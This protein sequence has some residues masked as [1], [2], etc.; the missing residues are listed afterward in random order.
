M[1]TTTTLD[2]APQRRGRTRAPAISLAVLAA[3]LT[4][5]AAADPTPPDQTELRAGIEAKRERM[6]TEGFVTKNEVGAGALL[7]ASTE[8]GLY[9]EAPIQVE[10]I[11]DTLFTTHVALPANIVEGDYVA[12]VFL[13]QDKRVVDLHESIVGVRK[14]GMERW[15]FSLSRTQPLAYGLLALAV[16]LAAGWGA[17]ELFRVLRR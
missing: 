9:V 15:L 2:S 13:V 11:E 1:Q 16:A 17:S 14:V 3:A 12:R 10:V 6:R 7:I 8:P 4:P 5:I